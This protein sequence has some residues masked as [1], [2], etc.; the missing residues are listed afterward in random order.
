MFK[1]LSLLVLTLSIYQVVAYASTAAPAIVGNTSNHAQ[2]VEFTP[3]KKIEAVIGEGELNRIQV[4]NNELMEVVGD[5]SKYSLHWSGDY[6]NVFIRPKIAAGET[7]E[8]SLV[9]AGGLAQDIRFTIGDVTAQTI[10]IGTPSNRHQQILTEERLL[11]SE[12]ALM[13]R[14]MID[15]VKDKYYVINIERYLSSAETNKTSIRQVKAYRYKDLSGAVLQ[16]INNSDKEIELREQDFSTIFKS[17][18]AV[19][20]ESRFIA[21][22]QLGRIFIIT[23]GETNAS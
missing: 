23:R 6:R 15:E 22:K 12:I 10:F 21:P 14:A 13:L 3:N 1:P 7:I 2:E 18:V 11:K 16:L 5:E 17:T 4:K 19:D 20:I 9:M 8:L